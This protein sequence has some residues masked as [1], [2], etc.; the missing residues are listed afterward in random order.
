MAR[1]TS[2]GTGWCADASSRGHGGYSQRTAGTSCRSPRPATARSH[3]NLAQDARLT[4]LGRQALAAR[5]ATGVSL[6]R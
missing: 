2:G 3:A 5:A 6:V 4:L 1:C